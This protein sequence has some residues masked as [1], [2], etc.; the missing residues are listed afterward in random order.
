M[1]LGGGKQEAE[2]TSFIG[3]FY[4]KNYIPA[5]SDDPESLINSLS[6]KNIT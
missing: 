3:L 6:Y 1:Q 2:I 5:N 4:R